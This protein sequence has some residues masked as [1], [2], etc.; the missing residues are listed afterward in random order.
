MCEVWCSHLPSVASRLL[1]AVNDLTATNLDKKTWKS[2]RLRFCEK[3]GTHNGSHRSIMSLFTWAQLRTLLLI[4][5]SSTRKRSI[6][7]KLCWKKYSMAG[8]IAGISW[9]KLAWVGS[10][11]GSWWRRFN[12]GQRTVEVR[13]FLTGPIFPDLLREIHQFFLYREYSS[14]VIR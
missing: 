2:T 4:V 3:T 8:A 5:M 7:T 1:S 13:R 9:M 6:A 10:S 14:C 11:P 12:V